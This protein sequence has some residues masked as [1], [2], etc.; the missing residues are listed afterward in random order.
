[1]PSGQRNW[2]RA[3]STRAILEGHNH[4][5]RYRPVRPTLRESLH[6][7]LHELTHVDGK[8]LRTADTLV[9]WTLGV[10]L[11]A[12]IEKKETRR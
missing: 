9:V 2:S 1:L 8:L 10:I 4:P 7:G 12:V 11:E 3:P 6:E 5:I